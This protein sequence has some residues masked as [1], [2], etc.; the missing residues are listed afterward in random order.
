[1]LACFAVAGSAMGKRKAPSEEA[2]AAGGNKPKPPSEDEATDGR[3]K[4]I[5][6]EATSPP[7]VVPAEA[8]DDV[9]LADDAV[10]VAAAATALAGEG[11][12][13]QSVAPPP[14]ATPQAAA[15]VVT[16]QRGAV[17]VSKFR[18]VSWDKQC[19]KWKSQI[20][21]KGKNKNLGYFEEDDE[22]GAAKVYAKSA[23]DNDVPGW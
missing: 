1:M 20:W 4:R 8:A 5:E 19:N 22:V 7:Q 23:M 16:D 12:A 3:A 18:G 17:K 15:A 2:G 11:D 14:P 21:V 13:A 9:A 6:K 10:A